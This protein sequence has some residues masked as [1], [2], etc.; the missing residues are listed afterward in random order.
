[1]L[2]L[3][4]AVT[5]ISLLCCAGGLAEILCL[6]GKGDLRAA[7]MRNLCEVFSC[8]R[9][10][11]IDMNSREVVQNK[12][13]ENLRVRWG[14]DGA[15]K[16]NVIY[17]GEGIPYD[18]LIWMLGRTFAEFVEAADAGKNHDQLE[19]ASHEFDGFTGIHTFKAS[20]GLM[21][22]FLDGHDLGK[23]YCPPQAQAG[24]SHILK[25]LPYD[26][27]RAGQAAVIIKLDT[28]SH[29]GVRHSAPSLASYT[30]HCSPSNLMSIY[31]I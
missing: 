9:T 13:W 20:T 7:K 16:G 23:G 19:Y 30:Q 11:I 1:M 14:R 21:K 12:I 6:T 27:E 24:T 25:V 15:G 31:C 10:G 28:R 26:T 22:F 5:G 3:K 17:W 8:F 18:R 29:K 4:P 2:D